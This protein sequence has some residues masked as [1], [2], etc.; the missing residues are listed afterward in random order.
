MA[1]GRNEKTGESDCRVQEHKKMHLHE[2]YTEVN[3]MC[4]TKSNKSYV[5]RDWVVT[6]EQ[7]NE[8]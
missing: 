4:A 8:G 3:R 6:E 7:E 1:L 2:L 5:L